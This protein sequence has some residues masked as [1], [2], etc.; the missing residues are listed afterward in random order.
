MFGGKFNRAKRGGGDT[1]RYGNKRQTCALGH[2]HRSK[3]ESAVCQMLQLREK[4]GELKLLQAEDH[5]YLTEARI[6]YIPD[7]KCQD[8]KTGEIFW[9]EAKG[10]ANDRWPILKK[11]WA[12]Y[13]MGR[14]E[15]WQGS[16][17]NPRL[18]ETIVPK[19]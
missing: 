17:V 11:L 9:V 15:I 14:L 18:V 12:H 10:F 4:A 19:N 5:V 13:G 7:F 1:K 8:T 16:H 3:L 2:S 6:G